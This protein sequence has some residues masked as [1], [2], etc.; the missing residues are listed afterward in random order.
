MEKS[1]LKYNLDIFNIKKHNVT[2]THQWQNMLYQLRKKCYLEYDK[3]EFKRF[4]NCLMMHNMMFEYY[5][6]CNTSIND[7]QI[8]KI[9]K[10][11][12]N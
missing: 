4:Y 3:K 9:N 5:H 6:H 12:T 7:I 11:L 2:K 10:L 8:I 1:T